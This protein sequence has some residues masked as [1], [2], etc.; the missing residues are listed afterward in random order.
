MASLIERLRKK[1]KDEAVKMLKEHNKCCIVRPT[2]FGKTGILTDILKDYKRVLYLYPAEIVRKTVLNFYYGAQVSDDTEIPNVTFC[3]YMM[4]IRLKKADIKRLY[5]DVD[6]IITDEAHKLGAA[7][8]I[9]GMERLLSVL[10]DVPLLGATASPER[11]DLVDEVSMFFDNHVVSKYTLHDAFKDGILKKPYYCYCSYTSSSAE[12]EKQTKLEIDKCDPDSK[13]E[14][15]D[16]LSARLIEISNLGKMEN[17]IKSTCDQYAKNK[18]YMKFIVFFASHDMVEQRKSS[19]EGWFKGAYPDYTVS[20][21]TVIA[22]DDYRDNINKLDTLYEQPKHI[23]LILCCDMLNMGY[24]VNS[25]T[26]VVMYR[27]TESGIIFIQQLGRVLSSGNNIPGIVFD[28]VDNLHREAMYDVLADRDAQKSKQIRRYNTLMNKKVRAEE[29]T[30]VELSEEEQAE[31]VDLIAL[32]D[33]GALNI[34]EKDGDSGWWRVANELTPEDLITTGHEATYREII[35]KTVAE[36]ISMRCRQA[37]ARWVEKGGVPE[38]RISDFILG[39][40]APKSVPLSPF[41]KAKSVS[42]KAVLDT[43][44]VV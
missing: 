14:L 33:S 38:P 31:L 2:G 3:T 39:Q 11:M 9:R 26:G 5:S 16:L 4:L 12:V 35:A 40:K 30:G 24:H 13:K 37:W 19:V 7:E 28:V 15:Y 18:D 6:L 43:M 22:S 20:S 17:V 23:D 8:T 36:P 32:I 27:G 42:V 10:P 41:C 25:L 21:L 44:G 34:E 1:T 29:N